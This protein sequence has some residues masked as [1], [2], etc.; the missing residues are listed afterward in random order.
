MGRS[1]RDVLAE[2]EATSTTYPDAMQRLEGPGTTLHFVA[3]WILEARAQISEFS[4]RGREAIADSLAG[5]EGLRDKAEDQANTRNALSRDWG[6]ARKRLNLA[7]RVLTPH[8]QHYGAAE[9]FRYGATWVGLLVGDAAA[10]TLV[11]IQAGEYPIFAAVMMVSLGVAAVTCGL[12]GHDLRYRALS[13]RLSRSGADAEGAALVEEV[14]AVSDKSWGL[15]VRVVISAATTGV[16]M[17]IGTFAFRTAVDGFPEGL[18]FGLWA[19]GIGAASWWNAWRHCDPARTV[20]A[21]F[22]NQEADAHLS[23]MKAPVGAIETRDR[24]LAVAREVFAAHV[25]RGQA[26]FYMMLAASARALAANPGVAGHGPEGDGHYL[27]SLEPPDLE[28]PAPLRPA[29]TDGAHAPD[30]SAGEEAHVATNGRVPRNLR[31][32]RVR[33]SGAGTGPARNGSTKDDP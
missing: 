23:Y 6:K 7:R 30:V 1:T 20:L 22:E 2:G 16:I 21:H 17:A 12:L 15:V 27:L 13:R 24:N 9:D 19:V 32:K 26:A 3:S 5:A 14:F 8:L 29:E 33:T 10:G 18:A 31:A 4:G 11:L 28:W 25:A